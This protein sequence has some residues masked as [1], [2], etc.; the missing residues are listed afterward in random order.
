MWLKWKYFLSWWK[1]GVL[2]QK[3]AAALVRLPGKR[4]R[5]GGWKPVLLAWLAMLLCSFLSPESSRKA[6]SRLSICRQQPSHRQYGAGPA[7]EDLAWFVR[8]L[9]TRCPILLSL[10]QCEHAVLLR[11]SPNRKGTQGSRAVQIS[12]AWGAGKSEDGK[13][14]LF[15]TPWTVQADCWSL[16]RWWW[17]FKRGRRKRKKWRSKRVIMIKTGRNGI[18]YLLAE[19]AMQTLVFARHL[20]TPLFYC[21]SVLPSRDIYGSSVGVFF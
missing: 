10:A 9:K 16:Q 12:G 15:P 6:P 3:D 14:T 21:H 2:S 4:R 17:R 5:W 19:S 7:C 8:L 20:P 11:A 1:E 18:K 13:S